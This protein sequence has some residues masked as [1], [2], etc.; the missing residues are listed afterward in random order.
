MKKLK[1]VCFSLVTLFLVLF[2]FVIFSVKVSASVSF[3]GSADDWFNHISQYDSGVAIC[4]TYVDVDDVKF[5]LLIVQEPSTEFNGHYFEYGLDWESESWM[6]FEPEL[7]EDLKIWARYGFGPVSADEWLEM[8]WG[9]A[10]DGFLYWNFAGQYW[11]IGHEGLWEEGYLEGYLDGYDAG[12]YHGYNEGLTTG[13][14]IGFNEGY[15]AG[16]VEGLL[17]GESEAYERGYTDGQKSKLAQ[18]NEKFYDGIEKWL[19]PAIITVIALG[20]FVTIAARKRRDE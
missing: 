5:G 7:A 9:D 11:Q 1:F 18:N 4:K 2:S 14:S 20:G 6:Y 16:Y 8:E 12:Y 17:A 13:E 3:T 15:D 10:F 19:V